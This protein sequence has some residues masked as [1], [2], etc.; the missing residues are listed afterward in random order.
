MKKAFLLLGLIASVLL[1]NAQT[2]TG[3]RVVAKNNFYLYD[4]WINRIQRDTNFLSNQSIPTSQ[5][6]ADFVNGRL[7]EVQPEKLIFNSGLTKIDSFVQFGGQL[8]N[9]TNLDANNLDFQLSNAANFS[10]STAN[11]LQFIGT[12]FLGN[13]VPP[14]IKM[15]NS[16]FD[17]LQYTRL[18]I[19]AP[20]LFNVDM[21]D[22]NSGQ[23]LNVAAN[24]G[25]FSISGNDPDYG[26]V[27][28]SIGNGKIQ[29][30][31]GKMFFNLPGVIATNNMNVLVQDGDN[32]TDPGIISTIAISELLPKYIVY[33]TVLSQS[34]TLAPNDYTLES[35]LPQ[36]VA[37]VW[38]RDS[39]GRY[40]G[41]LTGAN[42]PE[43]T[44]T[45]VHLTVS[46]ASGINTNYSFAFNSTN[47]FILQSAVYN[48]A[49]NSFEN[50]DGLLNRTPIEIKIYPPPLGS[51]E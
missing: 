31:E 26:Q 37:I 11:N 34:D 29:V 41:T 12:Y 51:G 13:G 15:E 5:A 10:F 46:N 39:V 16:N 44:E 6:V 35:T 24:T 8:L 30:L 21:I 7:A 17:Y 27:V 38:T 3:D 28:F 18:T 9:S 50:A 2:V 23:T 33:R 36:D 43:F 25:S 22:G 49:T 48:P 40:I 45:A 19:D 32:P 42:I 20:G 4:W 1:S 14:G 47:S